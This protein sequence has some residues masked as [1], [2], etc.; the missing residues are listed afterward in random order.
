MP[1]NVGKLPVINLDDGTY[2]HRKLNQIIHFPVFRLVEWRSEAELVGN[3][4]TPAAVGV[5]PSDDVPF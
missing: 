4:A 5:D 1:A 3:V 2:K